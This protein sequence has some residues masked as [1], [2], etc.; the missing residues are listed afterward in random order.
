MYFPSR[1]DR[2]QEVLGL[3]IPGLIFYF[4]FFRN[5]WVCAWKLGTEKCLVS[6]WF[7]FRTDAE[8]PASIQ[9]SWKLTGRLLCF[10]EASLPTSIGRRALSKKKDLP[11]KPLQKEFPFFFLTHRCGRGKCQS[12][13][14]QTARAACRRTACPELRSSAWSCSR[15]LEWQGTREP[16]DA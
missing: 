8:R 14:Q 4:P 9:K 5:A 1:A 2:A 13:A 11:A 7:T 10:W 16:V 12:A 15:W 6:F 3:Q